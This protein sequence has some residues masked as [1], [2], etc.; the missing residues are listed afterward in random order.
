MLNHEEAEDLA[1]GTGETHTVREFVS[2]AF[3]AAGIS[4]RWEGTGLEERGVTEEGRVVVRVKRELFRPLEAENYLA[5]YSKARKIL[6]WSP[7]TTFKEPVKI[8]VENDIKRESN[9][10]L[11]ADF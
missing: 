4:I 10:D 8:M 5:D 2:E 1:I 11:G 9:K 3:Y 7:K 6:G